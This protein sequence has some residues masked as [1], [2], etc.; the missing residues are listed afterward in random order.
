MPK[1]DLTIDETA[2]P[3][4]GLYLHCRLEEVLEN[5]PSGFADKP[6]IPFLHRD[7]IPVLAEKMIIAENEFP[8][9]DTRGVFTEGAD[10]KG[11]DW[12]GNVPSLQLYLFSPDSTE[13]RKI[14]SD[15]PQMHLGNSGHLFPYTVEGWKDV[16]LETLITV[17]HKS[18]KPRLGIKTNL[19]FT[20]PINVGDR[21]YYHNLKTVLEKLRAK[22][23]GI[24]NV[25]E[26]S[27]W[28]SG[29]EISI[30]RVSLLPGNYSDH[31]WAMRSFFTD[32]NRLLGVDELKSAIRAE[33]VRTWMRSRLDSMRKDYSEYFYPKLVQAG[34][35]DLEGYLDA[36]LKVISY[37]SMQRL[38][39]ISKQRLNTAA[40]LVRN[41]DGLCKLLKIIK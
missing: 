30:E 31:D 24:E 19:F 14:I 20:D 15:N 18:P 33:E 36:A 21:S 28:G 23:F 11:Y 34:D 32:F 17:D 25:V 40:D 10:N 22:L 16:Y 12:T 27:G 7:L 37:G 41:D 2:D 13:Q 1:I 5:R 4:S 35:T 9:D 26:M 29:S 38:K 3:R 39:V 8:I 6:K